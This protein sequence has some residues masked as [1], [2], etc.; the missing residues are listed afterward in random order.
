MIF[1]DMAKYLKNRYE[2]VSVYKVMKKNGWKIHVKPA[3]IERKDVQE[4]QK[5]RSSKDILTP[6]GV[7]I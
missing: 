1:K 4:R 7:F 5:W 6:L 3:K 2:S